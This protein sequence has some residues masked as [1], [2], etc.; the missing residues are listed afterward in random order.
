[1]KRVVPW[2]ITLALLIGAW[3]VALVTPD[4]EDAP[5][6]FISSATIGQPIEG[7]NIAITVHEVH[8]AEAISTST[9]WSADGTW[10]VVDLDAAAV[11]TQYGILLNATLIVEGRTFVATERGVAEPL[12]NISLLKTQLVPGIPKRG[13]VA[14]PIPEDAEAGTVTVEFTA[15]QAPYDSIIALTVDLSTVPV[16]DEVRLVPVD[17][18]A[19]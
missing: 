5:R 4:T 14:F 9:G 17:W 8:L 18:S 2:L 10:F 3:L 12:E 11:V 13:M 16:E 7:R 19:R 1:M 15:S 6:A